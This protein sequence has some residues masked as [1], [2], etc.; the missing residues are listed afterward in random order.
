MNIKLAILVAVS[1]LMISPGIFA[2]SPASN[3]E[4]RI[5]VDNSGTVFPDHAEREA[6]V[7]ADGVDGTTVENTHGELIGDIDRV[8]QDK[9]GNKLAILG[10]AD[11]LKEVAVPVEELQWK[12]SGEAI[13]QT[14]VIDATMS[15]LE[16]RKDIDPFDYEELDAGE[17]SRQE[18]ARFEEEA[19]SSQ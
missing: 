2:D 3:E 17:F 7:E 19:S 1:S 8:V 6:Y 10:L 11:S 16:S 18:F 4:T 13:N 12:T 14:L 9:S 15:E 5:S